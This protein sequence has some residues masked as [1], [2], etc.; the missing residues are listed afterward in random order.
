[1]GWLVLAAGQARRFGA[2]K[3]LTQVDEQRTVVQ[4]V[5]ANLQVSG[6]P[7]LVITR[8]G[9]TQLQALLDSHNVPWS[10]CDN[11]S[12]GMGHTLAW[13]VTEIECRWSWCG[14]VLGDMPFISPETYEILSRHAH[15]DKI[16]VPRLFGNSEVGE[17]RRGHPV[18]FGAAF[19][20]E[21]RELSDD[22]GARSLIRQ[23]AEKVEE[24]PVGDEGILLDIDTPRDLIVNRKR[25]KS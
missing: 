3:L 23:Y 20:P 4:Q 25:I 16:I 6:I 7:T 11:A 1:M 17:S 2:D 22:T 18:L 5:L 13:G 24:V 14:V 12:L 21:L 19:F 9:H 8:P 10:C 15:S